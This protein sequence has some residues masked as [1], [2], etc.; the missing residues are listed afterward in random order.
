MLICSCSLVSWRWILPVGCCVWIHN[1]S[2]WWDLRV[3]VCFFLGFFLFMR[4]TDIFNLLFFKSVTFSWLNNNLL[5]AWSFGLRRG[6]NT[7]F[8]MGFPLLQ[9]LYLIIFANFIWKFIFRQN[10]KPSFNVEVWRLRSF[11]SGKRTFLS[12]KFTSTFL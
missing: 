3:F 2:V 8:L 6:K 11:F 4:T 7:T 10:I 5:I 12:R 9:F 1:V